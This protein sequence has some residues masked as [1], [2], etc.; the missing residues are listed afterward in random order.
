MNEVKDIKHKVFFHGKLAKDYG[1]KP[2]TIY[3]NSL[4][5]VF[6]GLCANLGEGFKNVIRLGRWHI[7]SGPRKS[8]SDKP[9]N[10]DALLS[11]EDVTLG[12]LEE[13]LHVFP[14]V[15]GAS[16]VLKVIV[17]VILVII[18]VVVGVIFSW[19]GV[20][21]MAGFGI[22]S[23]GVS[24]I[25]GGAMQMMARNPT[26]N[27]YQNASVAQK[28][29]FV[30]NGAVNTMEQGGPVPLIYGLHLTGSTVISAGVDIEQL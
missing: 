19:T 6:G 27:N 14:E 10:S 11:E 20:G 18:G 9:Q 30:F 28:A 25:V 16:G 15:Q 26:I 24:M 12:G 22:A 13:E 4:Q 8:K 29:S 5:D 17:G 21:G 23:M 1:K 2:F 3:A 7:S